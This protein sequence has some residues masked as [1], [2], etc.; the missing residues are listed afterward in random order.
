MNRTETSIGEAIVGLLE[1]YG[2]DTVLLGQ[3]LVVLLWNND[4][5]GQIWDG[6]VRAGIQPNAVWARNPD[7]QLL[8]RAYGCAAEKPG[9]LDEL[10][11]AIKCALAARTPS[12]IEMTP[13]MVRA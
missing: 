9:N 10:A 7:F 5:L 1:S 13:A 8:A 4:S 12:V 3:P 11:A 2:V 6:M